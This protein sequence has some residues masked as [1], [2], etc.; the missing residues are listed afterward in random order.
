MPVDE[1]PRAAVEREVAGT[2]HLHRLPH[3]R[4]GVGGPVG[5]FAGHRGEARLAVIQPEEHQVGIFGR[6]GQR[7]PRERARSRIEL[8]QQP[9]EQQQP[10]LPVGQP[11]ERI[12]VGADVVGAVERRTGECDHLPVIAARSATTALLNASVS[13]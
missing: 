12:G 10:R 8:R 13:G 6:V 1:A 4:L 5:P 7:A 9:V 3:L 11:G 2:E